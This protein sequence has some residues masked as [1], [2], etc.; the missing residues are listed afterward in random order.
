MH[1][2]EKTNTI[3]HLCWIKKTKEPI[4]L[5]F[6][7]FIPVFRKSLV[8]KKKKKTQSPYIPHRIR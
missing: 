4:T 5:E 8:H 6:A 3:G 7:W 1:A 2:F